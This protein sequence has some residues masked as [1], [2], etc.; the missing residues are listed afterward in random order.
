MDFYGFI[1]STETSDTNTH[2]HIHAGIYVHYWPKVTRQPLFFHRKAYQ[3]DFAR[4]AITQKAFDEI[5]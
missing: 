5:R 3:T 4:T 2:T 1:E